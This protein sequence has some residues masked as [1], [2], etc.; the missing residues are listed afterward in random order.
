M[1]LTY[2]QKWLE[3]LA[4]D[5]NAKSRLDPQVI[6]AYRNRIAQIIRAEDERELRALKSAHFE[7]LTELPGKYSI[8]LFGGWRVIFEIHAGK[9]KNTI[10]VTDIGDYH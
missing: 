5:L 10:H 3:T 9:P 2:D 7:K 6:R 4:T 1:N 8:R